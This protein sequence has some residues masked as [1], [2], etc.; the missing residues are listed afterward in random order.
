M[1]KEQLQS[2]LEEG[3]ANAGAV[4][5]QIDRFIS[6]ASTYANNIE[7]AGIYAPGSIL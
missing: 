2:C 7:G 1:N 3:K 5:T 4:Q 6:E